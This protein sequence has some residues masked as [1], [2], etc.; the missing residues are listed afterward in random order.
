MLLNV[1]QNVQTWVK[2]LCLGM[3]HPFQILIDT[4]IEMILIQFKLKRWTMANTDIP[5]NSSS[6]VRY[7]V[8]S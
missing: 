8:F 5:R 7:E 3:L 4:L 6:F 2:R 1:R